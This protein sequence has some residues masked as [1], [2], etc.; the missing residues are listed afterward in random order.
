MFVEKFL[1][2]YYFDD[3]DFILLCVG[4]RKDYTLSALTELSVHNVPMINDTRHLVLI[5]IEGE[6]NSFA[7][8]HGS[9]NIYV[10]LLGAVVADAL[11]CF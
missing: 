6:E 2:T 1:L 5:S 9:L 11:F 3:A 7:S 8:I 4:A 10:L